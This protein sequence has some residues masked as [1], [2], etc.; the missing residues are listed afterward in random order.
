[1]TVDRI[2]GSFRDPSGGVYSVNGRILRTVTETYAHQF[3][4]VHRTGLLDRLRARGWLLP[5]EF[6]DDE[7]SSLFP[8]QGI[9]H[10]L[11]VP[12]LLFVSHPY[13]WPFSALKSA[14]LLHLD[15]QVSALEAGVTLSDASAYNVQFQGP[16]PVFIDHLSFRRYEPGEI[17][18]AHR[19]FCEQFLLPLLLRALFGISHNAW[20]RGNLEGIPL[21]DFRRLLKWQHCLD[22]NLLKHVVLHAWLHQN[23]K[24]LEGEFSAV[25]NVSSA[26][27]VAAF[28]RLLIGLRAW[29]QKLTPADSAMST[30]QDYARTNSYR[31]DEVHIKRRFVHEFVETE[32]PKHL[33]DLGCNAGD[34]AKV[35]LEAGASHVIGFDSDQGALEACFVRAVDERLAI[36]PVFLDIANPSPNQ[37]WQESERS[38]LRGRGHADAVLALALI[39]HLVIAKNI[40]LDQVLDWL[41]SLAPLGILEFIPKADPMVQRLLSLREDI[42]SSYS[43]E[44]CLAH[45]ETKARIVKTCHLSSQGRTLVWYERRNQ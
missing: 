16:I 19:Q 11:E 5:Y 33:W 18:T 4:F 25:R 41:I 27:P 3:H 22:S 45:L 14:A 20:Y 38:G 37:G 36:Q 12:R 10:L 35:A 29:I 31:T 7:I 34:Y 8:G 26:L 24:G 6:V 17:W 9:E 39:H 40:P 15:V 30:W 43:L 44:T 23:S 2:H 21:E 32:R 1:M 13:E 28:R 42:F